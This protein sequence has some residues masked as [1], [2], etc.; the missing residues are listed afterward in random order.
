MYDSGL[1]YWRY[2]EDPDQLSQRGV[3]V[4]KS[5]LITG[6]ASGLAVAFAR[7]LAMQGFDLFLNYRESREPCDRLADALARDCGVYAAPVQAD[8]S[9]PADVERL[10]DAVAGRDGTLTVLVHSAGPFVFARKRL[11]DYTDE[12]W[13]EMQD[14]NLSS[15]FY[16]I[17]RAIRLMRPQGFGR[18][19]TVG[20][21]HVESSPGWVYRAAYAAAK[22]GLASLTRSVALEERENGITAN[23]ICPGDI[24]S[25]D[26]EAE[27]PDTFGPLGAPGARSPVGG[28]LARIVSFLVSPDAQFVTGNVLSATGDVDVLGRYHGG[29]EEVFDE[30]YFSVGDRVRVAP[31]GRV[32]VVTGRQDSRNRRTLYTVSDGG[33]QTKWTIDQLLEVDEIGT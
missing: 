22:T 3:S 27:S 29:R 24:R 32:G 19:V 9:R 17:R 16:L 14:G 23:M 6:S 30:R 28:D 21:Q 11:A 15:A 5:A 10:M 33:S 20:F 13:R 26:K 1:L 18:I 4:P 12:E 31:S 8:V 2:Q 7:T 25:G